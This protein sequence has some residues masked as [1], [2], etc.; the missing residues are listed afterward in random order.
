MIRSGLIVLAFFTVASATMWAVDSNNVGSTR[1][2][3]DNWSN[4]FDPETIAVC[5]AAAGDTFFCRGNNTF[6]ASF[7]L[8]S[9]DGTITARYKFI[10]VKSSTTNWPPQTSDYAVDSASRPVW[11]MSTTY[12]LT[13]GDSTDLQGL[14]LIGAGG[15]LLTHGTIDKFR[16]CTLH[17]NQGTSNTEYVIAIG[18]TSVF[19]SCTIISDNGSGCGGPAG[20]RFFNCTFRCKGTA[21]TC[22]GQHSYTGCNFLDCGVVFNTT[23]DQNHQFQFCNFWSNDTVY[24]ATT[25]YGVVFSNCAFKGNG[26]EFYSSSTTKITLR[27]NIIDTVNVSGIDTTNYTL[28]GNLIGNVGWISISTGN[29]SIPESSP[30]YGKGRW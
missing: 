13:I 17:H 19:D 18:G 7:N 10:F 27:N 5:A 11:N 25:D 22:T 16:Y 15:N 4:P 12:I 14:H 26:M 3:G 29:D 1:T 28:N 20:T 9:L 2:D 21:I 30:A 24:K 8:G 23:A 6:G